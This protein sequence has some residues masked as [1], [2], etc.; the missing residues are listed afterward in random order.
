MASVSKEQSRELLKESQATTQALD[1]EVPANTHEA[2]TE[3]H[4]AEVSHEATLFA[5]PMYHVGNF[6][7]TNALVTS[8]VAV[9]IIV[10][11]AVMLRKKLATIPKGIQNVFELFIEGALSLCDQVTGDRNISQKIFPI[12]SSVFFFILINNW[13]GLI[14]GVGSFGYI[15]THDGHD[16]FVPFLR[17]GTADLNT[18]LALGLISVIG[19]NI[20]GIISIGAWKMFNKYI[21]INALLEIPKKVLK[22]PVVLVTAPINIFVGLIEIV[23]EIAKIASLSLRLFG[24]VFAGE[25]LLGA[26]SALMAYFV[27]LPFIFMEVLVGFIQALIFSMLTMVYFTIAAQ[28]HSHDEHHEGEMHPAH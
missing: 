1:H 20:F 24:N 22:D 8:W 23:G 14:P 26:M 25:V 5:E 28:D 4:E 15:Q 3:E 12:V 18:T 10:L 17:G 6:A 7:I 9:A 13:M 2:S 21:N 16:V 11:L 27:P 19:S